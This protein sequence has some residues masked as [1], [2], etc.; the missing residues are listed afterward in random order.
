MKLPELLELMSAFDRTTLSSLRFE[1]ADAKIK[2]EKSAP[3]VYA[4]PT[5]AT[6]PAPVPQT[7]PMPSGTVVTAPIVGVVYCAAAPGKPPYVTTGQTVKQGDILCLIEAMKTINEVKA[8]TD[9][10]VK[11]ILFTD[12]ELKEFAAPLV[13]IGA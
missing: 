2:L 1:T 9:G 3:A 8:P 7:E 13:V 10:V 4:A 11:E 5:P 6:C 12:G